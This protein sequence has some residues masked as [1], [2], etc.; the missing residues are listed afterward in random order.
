MSAKLPV[1]PVRKTF[2]PSLHQENDD[3]AKAA[4]VE[5][6]KG[7]DFVSS[8]AQNENIYGVD[9]KFTDGDYARSLEVEVKR[10]WKGPAFPYS[11]VQVPERKVKYF[12]TGS[13]YLLLNNEATVCIVIDAETILAS[14]KVEVP[15]KYVSSGE[16]FFQVPVSKALIHN[17][18]KTIQTSESICCPKMNLTRQPDESWFCVSCSKTQT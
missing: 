2:S 12:E 14:P 16:M 15:N 7:F 3:L 8:I 9:L 11:T 10:V 6:L 1:S 5:F 4:G 13:D 17:F 18:P